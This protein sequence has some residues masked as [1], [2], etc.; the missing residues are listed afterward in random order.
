M[1]DIDQLV[2]QANKEILDR[3]DKF[4]KIKIAYE[5]ELDRE[6]IHEEIN[7]KD[8]V[9]NH[10]KVAAHVINLASSLLDMAKNDPERLVNFRQAARIIF[11]A[12]RSDGKD[13]LLMVAPLLEFID[14]SQKPTT[15][16]AE[17]LKALISQRTLIWLKDELGSLCK[18]PEV[19]EQLMEDIEK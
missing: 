17:K 11:G 3:M 6:I 12:F 13:A 9:E 7:L 5:E 18:R 19:F 4:D 15:D 16:E 1:I 10:L 14:S 2:V 8:K